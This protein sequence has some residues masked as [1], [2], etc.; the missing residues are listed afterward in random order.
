MMKGKHLDTNSLEF[1]PLSK[2]KFKCC[3]KWHILVIN[4]HVLI[5]S[6]S[7]SKL[8]DQ[9]GWIHGQCSTRGSRFFGKIEYIIHDRFNNEI[10][11]VLVSHAKIRSPLPDLTDV[12]SRNHLQLR[13]LNLNAFISLLHLVCIAALVEVNIRGVKK[14]ITNTSWLVKQTRSYQ[15]CN[16]MLNVAQTTPPL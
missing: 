12:F 15:G 3:P 2:W 6:P 7:W 8:A 10:Y 9:N 5:T 13:M 1:W 11:C 4:H 14:P 16:D